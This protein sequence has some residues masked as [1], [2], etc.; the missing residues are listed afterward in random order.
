MPQGRENVNAIWLF[1]RI[2][3]MSCHE[4]FHR[5]IEKTKKKSAR[6]KFEGWGKYSN[7]GNAPILHGLKE[8]LL[9][10]GG[11]TQTDILDACKRILGGRIS[12]FNLEVPLGPSENLFPADIWRLDPVTGTLWPGAE[13]Y[14]F[15][16]PY[17]HERQKGDIKYVWEINRLQF[18][19]PLAAAVHFDGDKAAL[20]VIEACIAS[21]YDANP[22][23]RGVAWNSSIEIAIRAISLLVVSC[24]AGA[25]FCVDSVQRTRA[26]LKA[27]LFALE[28]YPSCFSSAN[29]HFLA[30]TA[31][32]FLI[33]LA[34]PDLDVDGVIG[35][36]AGR[37][38][39]KE[40]CNQFYSDG[41][42]A[43]QSVTYGGSSAE[44]LLLCD[45]VGRSA[46]SPLN[47]CVRERLERFTEFVSWLS[48]RKG[49][50]PAIG[51]DDQGRV[52]CF[53]PYDSGYTSGVAQAIKPLSLEQGLRAFPE[54]GYSVI[55]NNRWHVIFDHGPLGYLSIAA[56]GHA[57]ALS[58][59]ASLDGN[60]LFVDPGTYLYH[61]GGAWRDWFRG[62]SSHN[63]LNIH[64][65][66]QSIITGSFNWA[67]KAN[68]VLEDIS[69][70]PEWVIAAKHD[71][72]CKRFGV[73]HYRKIRGNNHR[74]VIK[75][76]LVGG[77][78]Q[79]AE[80][81]FQLAPGYTV[82]DKNA[83]LVIKRGGKA[84]ATM[85]FQGAGSYYVAAGQTFGD[86]GGWYS[87]SFGLK[88]PALRIAW[89]GEV[90]EQGVTT[91]ISAT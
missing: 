74:I 57:D 45:D 42:P 20:A 65:K 43:E 55:R 67:N 79:E 35:T 25:S 15:D 70:F 36:N 46:G 10:Y 2:R 9:L 31:G 23:F 64:G 44:L 26:I 40:A 1:N 82:S 63:T 72:Y 18:L 81:V 87:P 7:L 85:Q 30:E 80:I 62:T 12:T 83:S 86:R 51:D 32:K 58:I 52:F 4:I 61:S 56:H 47:P 3:S 73:T 88:I 37:T 59:V 5:V 29:N 77:Q 27:S 49:R 34:M 16:I 84:V 91:F 6:N 71:G 17:R 13:T 54:G 66:N 90:D 76:Q 89:R 69:G 39:E 41:V 19:Q 24:L 33:A 68:A 60:P 22:P 38:L 75:D 14:C 11:Q 48:D 28:R 78:M 8:R 53:V 50:V 21:W